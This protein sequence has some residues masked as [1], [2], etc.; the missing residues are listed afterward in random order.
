M[1]KFKLTLF[2]KIAIFIIA[3]AVILGGTYF[4]GGSKM[5]KLPFTK[6]AETPTYTEVPDTNKAQENVINISTDEWIGSKNLLDANGGLTTKSG[7]IFDKLGIKVNIT[8]VNDGTQSSNALIKGN[9]DAAVYTVNRYAFLFDKFKENKVETVM[10]FIDNV[11]F[12]GDGIIA[13]QNI[14]RIEDLVG[15][16]IAVPRYSEAQTL[17]HWLL[18][19][20]SLTVAQKADIVK[21]MKMFDTPDDAAKAFFGGQVDAAATW[22]PFL[23][24]ATTTTGARV[25]FSTKAATNVIMDG[26]VFRKDYIDAHPETVKKMIEGLLQAESLYATSF[27]P[28]KNSMPLFATETDENIKAMTD[29]AKLTNYGTNKELMSGVAQNLFADMSDIWKSVG[30]KAYPEAA[31]TAID[32]TLLKDLADKFPDQKPIVTKI[33]EVQK[34]EA[35]KQDVNQALL[36]KRLSINFET[37]FASISADSFKALNEFVNDAKILNSTVIQIEGNTDSVGNAEANRILSEKRARSVAIYMQS[38]GV[39][40]SR[41]VIVGNGI[42]KP[43][44]DNATDAG[45]AQNRR[46]DIYFKVVK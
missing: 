32:G 3:A 12:G 9:L 42:N 26:I 22:E 5:V 1:K 10:P 19:R 28:I 45:K 41:F 21:N 20:S 4:M 37:G 7:S 27:D 14:M 46:T 13:K 11:S 39:D 6:E 34:E 40:S 23:T 33:T 15:K 31:A 44:A 16:T 8:I 24:Q 43:I 35:K 17:I 29:T 18:E 36:T 38:Q 30:E 2:S 25:L